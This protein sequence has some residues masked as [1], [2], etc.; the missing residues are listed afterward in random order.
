MV[1]KFL[2]SYEHTYIHKN[3]YFFLW[4]FQ[5]SGPTRKPDKNLNSDPHQNAGSVTMPLISVAD[6]WH[7]CADPDPQIRIR[8][9]FY[10]D[11][12]PWIRH[13]FSL[14]K[15]KFNILP[16]HFFS[17]LSYVDQSGP[18]KHWQVR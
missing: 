6:P 11:P 14:I 5:G 8:F 2:P 9:Y 15:K 3:T 13:L 10:P 12:G 17:L 4:H 16:T 1:P 18:I 7:F